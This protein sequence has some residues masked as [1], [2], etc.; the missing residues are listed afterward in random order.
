MKN[1]FWIL[2]ATAC[3]SALYFAQQPSKRTVSPQA[4]ARIEREV[5]H[6]L[7]MIP[8][9]GVFDNLAYQVNGYDVTLTGSVTQPIIK[10]SAERA[11]KSIEGVEKIDNKI[12]VLP[13]NTADNQIRLA[14]YRAIYGSS[15]LERYALQSIPSIHLIVNT[16][17]VTLEGAVATKGDADMATIRAKTV[18]GV[19][20][21][22]SNLKI[23]T[24]SK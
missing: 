7:L 17:T 23:D 3:L 1:M 20:S 13:V 10:A 22:T 11:V 8:Q 12:V 21:V 4:Q 15:A 24:P 14:V 16:G 2:S 6:E 9:Y 5:R 18:G 19:F